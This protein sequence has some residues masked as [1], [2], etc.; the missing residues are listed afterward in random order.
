M[1]DSDR[2]FY[3]RATLIRHLLIFLH[4]SKEDN[5]SLQ[6]YHQRLATYT[7]WPSSPTPELMALAGFHH[8]HTQL[9]DLFKCVDCGITLDGWEPHDDPIQEHSR[10]S[11]SCPH[12]QQLQKDKQGIRGW[13][14]SL[15]ADQASPTTPLPAYRSTSPPP[16]TYPPIKTKNYMTV[17]DLFMR[18][19]PLKSVQSARPIR[20]T[21]LPTMSIH[22]LYAKFHKSSMQT[23]PTF[24]KPSAARQLPRRLPESSL[25]ARKMSKSKYPVNRLPSA[26]QHFAEI[27]RPKSF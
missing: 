19:A 25:A 24:T 13:L 10:R 15:S 22:D 20:P 11:E 6:T 1:G 4:R 18:Y 12:V 27:V 23:N 8:T 9:K 21:A 16:P 17:D 3:N 2:P 5:T 26:I 7:S 14:Q